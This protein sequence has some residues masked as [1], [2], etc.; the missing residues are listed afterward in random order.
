M[1]VEE[2]HDWMIENERMYNKYGITFWQT[3]ISKKLTVG[4][5]PTTSGSQGACLT[6]VLQPLPKDLQK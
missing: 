3:I 2:Y 5:E 4:V 1:N 6:A